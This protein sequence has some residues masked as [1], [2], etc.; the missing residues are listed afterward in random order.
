MCSHER[1]AG[2]SGMS[3]AP[4]RTAPQVPNEKMPV[5]FT[6][7]HYA[8]SGLFWAGLR[9]YQDGSALETLHQVIGDKTVLIP[10]IARS[11]WRSQMGHS[12]QA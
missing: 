3:R 9:A 5:R 2:P 4:S 7:W 8:P 11:S 12:D 6:D 1:H 10:S